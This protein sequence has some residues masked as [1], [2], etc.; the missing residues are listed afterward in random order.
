MQLASRCLWI[1]ELRNRTCVWLGGKLLPFG[2]F[3]S[4][5]YMYTRKGRFMEV[6]LNNP[7]DMIFK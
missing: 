3:L 4:V 7:E 1:F 6:I 2:P 5:P